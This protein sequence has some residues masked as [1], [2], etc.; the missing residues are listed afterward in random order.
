MASSI[1]HR[2]QKIALRRRAL[3]EFLCS[4]PDAQALGAVLER[5]NLAW[6]QVQTTQA[7]LNSETSQWRK[8]VAHTTDRAGGTRRVIQSPYRFSAATSGLRGPA[9][10]RGEHN[11]EVLRDWIGATDAEVVGLAERGILQA[12]AAGRSGSV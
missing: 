3:S 5:A 8:T 9:P 2:Q 11:A 1:P 12:E 4:F 6:G 7:A 10:Y